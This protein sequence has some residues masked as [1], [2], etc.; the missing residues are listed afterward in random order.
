MRDEGYEVAVA[1]DGQKALDQLGAESFGVI[2]ADLK[3]PKVDG[4]ALLKE[5][6]LRAIPTECIIV[7]G[8]ATVD[9]AVQAM[10]E[11]AYDYVEKP[12]TADKLNRLKALIPKAVEK[13]NVQQKNRELSSKLEGLTHFGE[14]T[15][16]SEEMR[17]VYQ[18]IEAVAPSTA[19]VLIFGE[20]GTGKE[21]VARA[22]HSKSER[23][24]GPFFALNCAALP[25]DILENELFG[26]EK[27]A[28]TGSVNEKPGAFEMADGGTI[29]LDEIAEM[30]PDIQVK[31][32]RA[33]ESRTIRRLGGKKEIEVDIRIVAA[34]NRDI[35]KALSE[36]DL[37][38]DLYYRLAVVELF[39]PPLRERVGDIKLLA[40]EF[41]V[42]FAEQNGKPMSGFDDAAWEWIL[43]YN[44]P[45]NVRELKN[46]VERA[47]IMSRGDKI[48]AADIMPRHLRR[49]VDPSASIT[50]PPG[51]TLADTRRQMV[52][53][54]FA[55]TNGDYTRTATIVGMA[56]GDVRAEIASLLN[57]SDRAGAASST[58]NGAHRSMKAAESPAAAPKSSKPVAKASKAK[59]R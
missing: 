14:L 40:N 34:T 11:G 37:R 18:I 58:A 10:R 27:G 53:R 54:A 31:L 56:P 29:F 16:Q 38:D 24:K 26:H 28:F 7:T 15:G 30:P 45:G 49:G 21:L 57:G 19:S 4:L 5:L 3:M 32:L 51:A 20:S 12:L 48:T 47:V 6:Q 8:Q 17:A 22:V 9:S 33:I 42:R 41:L 35:Q 13:F 23:A 55:S 44:W 59:K 2:L 25:K 52:L 1:V 50:V 43:S 46:A 39:L 36:N